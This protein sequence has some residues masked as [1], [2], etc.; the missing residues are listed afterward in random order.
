[1]YNLLLTAIEY[2]TE[3]LQ[4]C[5]C[6]LQCFTKQFVLEGLSIVLK[7]NYFYINKSFFHQI[8]GF[9]MGL[10]YAVVGSSLVVVY[11][12]IKL[13]ALLCQVYPQD[14]VEHTHKIFITKLL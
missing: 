13:C 7:F 4:N 3:H 10:K 6:L 9:K 11:K 1:M 2:L 5:L 8:K 14:F 12:E